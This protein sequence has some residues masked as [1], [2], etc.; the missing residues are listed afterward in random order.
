MLLVSVLGIASKLMLLQ[1]MFCKNYPVVGFVFQILLDVVLVFN[2][3]SSLSQKKHSVK[4]TQ[5]GIEAYR[6]FYPADK[7]YIT[8]ECVW[9]TDKFILLEKSHMGDVNSQEE[10]SGSKIPAGDPSVRYQSLEAFLGDDEPDSEKADKDHAAAERPTT[11]IDE[12]KINLLA[13]PSDDGKQVDGTSKVGDDS[14][15]SETPGHEFTQEGDLLAASSSSP[16]SNPS[17]VKSSTKKVAF[18]SVSVKKP[19][20][21]TSNSLDLNVK[22]IE[23]KS[24]EQEDKFYNLLTGGNLKDSLF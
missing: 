23:K 8:L 22:E 10:D 5:E 20:P 3:V 6:E 11:N 1:S 9:S 12:N 19:A 17:K 7:E 16:S 24:D 15:T 18:V 13:S 2:M 14:G 4:I 21:S